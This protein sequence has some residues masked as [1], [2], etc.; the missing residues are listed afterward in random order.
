[1][2]SDTPVATEV[3]CSDRFLLPHPADTDEK[4]PDIRGIKPAVTIQVFIEPVMM[5][6]IGTPDSRPLIIPRR[7]YR[8]GV[9]LPA[10]VMP[11]AAI[12]NMMPRILP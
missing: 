6:W 2:V 4:Q 12:M 10:P 9:Q 3:R 8:A 1:M 7:Q 5:I 11:V